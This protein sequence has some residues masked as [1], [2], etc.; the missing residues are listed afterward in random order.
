VRG[1]APLA[2]PVCENP[3]EEGLHVS[4]V[5]VSSTPVNVSVYQKSSNIPSKRFY[6]QFCGLPLPVYKGKG[7]P[8]LYHSDCA[9]LKKALGYALSHLETGVFSPM[10]ALHL[11]IMLNQAANNIV[12]LEGGAA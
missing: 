5:P 12:P 4:N 7:R 6:C 3:I 9:K 11:R 10:A 1:T 2:G 8:P